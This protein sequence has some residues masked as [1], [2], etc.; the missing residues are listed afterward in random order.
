[1]NTT[2]AIRTR[3]LAT[4]N[5]SKIIVPEFYET[6]IVKNNAVVKRYKVIY[7]ASVSGN[8][9]YKDIVGVGRTEMDAF[10]KLNDSL[11]STFKVRH[12]DKYN[13]IVNEIKKEKAAAS[14]TDEDNSEEN[15]EN[16]EMSKDSTLAENAA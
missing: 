10:K 5:L 3:V 7:K 13:E 14:S 6:A 4:M 9:E 15:K 8:D 2:T 1:M 12:S 11:F 16:A